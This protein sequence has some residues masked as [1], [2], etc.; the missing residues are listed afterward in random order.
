MLA[1]A[2]SLLF[3]FVAFAT[4]ADLYASI[5]KGTRRRRKILEEL[6]RAERVRPKAAPH[7]WQPQ[8]RRLAA[9]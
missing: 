7:R 2:L 8:A 3:G 5:T 6:A 9:A 1:I 4:I